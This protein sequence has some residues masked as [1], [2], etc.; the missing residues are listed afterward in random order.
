LAD[1]ASPEVTSIVLGKRAIEQGRAPACRQTKA[2]FVAIS[3]DLTGADWMIE[4]D[5]M[6]D[7]VDQH[8]QSETRRR[9]DAPEHSPPLRDRQRERV[10]ECAVASY[11][12]PADPRIIE[13][14][15]KG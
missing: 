3:L 1:P 13:R 14:C 6:A 10:P 4:A 9:K 7:F 12:P 2:L 8:R 15:L 5:R 11:S